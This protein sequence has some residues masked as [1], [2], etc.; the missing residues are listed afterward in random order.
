MKISQHGGKKSMKNLPTDTFCII[1]W[2][3]LNTTPNGEVLHCCITDERGQVGDLRTETL[4]DVWNNDKMRQLRV[5]LLNGEKPASCS[6]C[7]E[8]ESNNIQSFRH[9]ANLNFQSHLDNIAGKTNSDGSL[10]D[11]KLR[12][13]DFRFSNLCNMKCRMCGHQS[14]SA[15]HADMISLYGTDSVPADPVINVSD[16]SIQDLYQLLDEQID[17]V[18]EIYFAGGEPLIMD[19]HY[20]ILERL[21]ERGRS[22]VR[23]R[24]NTNLLKIKYKHWD[25][26]Q[27]W[28]HFNLVVINASIDA[29]G[30]RAEYIRNGT[31]WSTV[32]ENLRRLIAAPNVYIH[33]SPTIQ[34]LNLLHIPDLV[35]YLLD[36]GLD[37]KFLWMNN[38]LTTPRHYHINTLTD[39]VK[40]KVVDR[41]NRHISSLTDT[42]VANNLRQ[43]YDSMISYMESDHPSGDDL[44]VLRQQ[45]VDH[46]AKLDQLR[47]ENLLDVFPELAD[48][49]NTAYW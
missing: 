16:H 5:K 12:Y 43:Q 29:M 49:C 9:S 17:H 26:M 48:H 21:I 14:S 45:F 39:P 31:V 38:V 25:N 37:I 24:Y 1:P 13:W 6:K 34:V 36:I 11:M 19:E 28:Q 41:F 27:L 46:S 20:Y 2:I 15:W 33:A 47:S 4:Q 18:E 3:H 40:A 35:D 44:R 7:Y 23:I 30:Q 42:Q 8:Q 10:D 22:D 32:D